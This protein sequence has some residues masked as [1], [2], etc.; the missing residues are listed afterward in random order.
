MPLNID[1]D[2]LILLGPGFSLYFIFKKS[3]TIV[4]CIFSFIVGITGTVII[5]Y[6]VRSG[7]EKT[8]L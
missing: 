8:N 3:L 7:E 2:D 6:W 5:F 1:N 4:L